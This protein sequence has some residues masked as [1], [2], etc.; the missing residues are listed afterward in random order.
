MDY[1]MTGRSK[2]YIERRAHRG[3]RT[4]RFSAQ[5]YTSLAALVII[6]AALLAGCSGSDVFTGEAKE[7]REPTIELTNGPLKLR[8]GN[9]SPADPR[10]G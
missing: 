5:V 4:G 7:N 8:V 6:A 3:E 10:C 9:L 2:T 1:K